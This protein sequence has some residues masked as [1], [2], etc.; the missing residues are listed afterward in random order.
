MQ[1]NTIWEIQ[2]GPASTLKIEYELCEVGLEDLR[3]RRHDV[4]PSALARTLK[5]ED[6]GVSK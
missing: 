3:D 2:I 4:P 1:V 6:S 5:P